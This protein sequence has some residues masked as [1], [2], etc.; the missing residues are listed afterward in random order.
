MN[1]SG[2]TRLSDNSFDNLGYF[3]AFSFFQ[4]K[5]IVV[6]MIQIEDIHSIGLIEFESS[7]EDLDMPCLI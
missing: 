4:M 7:E 3:T 1:Y 2:V 5:Q 6:S